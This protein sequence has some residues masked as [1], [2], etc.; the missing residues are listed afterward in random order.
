MYFALSADSSPVYSAIFGPRQ[1]AQ[2]SMVTETCPPGAP[3]P[4][5]IILQVL[6]PWRSLF[7]QPKLTNGACA[8]FSRDSHKGGPIFNQQPRGPE[9]E[10]WLSTN[11]WTQMSTGMHTRSMSLHM[12]PGQA[13]NSMK[14]WETQN[15]NLVFKVVVKVWFLSE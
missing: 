8:E 2:Q 10:V 5:W 1:N 11:M 9:D 4:L 6:R 15:S 13:E 14:N 7:T 3:H 12:L